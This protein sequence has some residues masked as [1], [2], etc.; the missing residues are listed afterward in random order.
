MV[1]VAGQARDLAHGLP[2]NAASTAL[3]C[4]ALR[5]CRPACCISSSILSFAR[6]TLDW[7]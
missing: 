7:M 4:I 5:Y 2:R 6:C 1:V 3:G